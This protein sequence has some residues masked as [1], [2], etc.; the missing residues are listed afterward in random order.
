MPGRAALPSEPTLREARPET[1]AEWVTH[2]PG[3]PVRLATLCSMRLSAILVA[4]CLLP[5]PITSQTRWTP[6]AGAPTDFAPQLAFDPIQG[7]M[8]S[9]G[10]GPGLG[11]FNETWAEIGGAWRRIESA[12]IPSARAH[13]RMVTDWTRSRVVCF[14]GALEFLASPPA[15]DETWEWDGVDWQRRTTPNRPAARPTAWRS[16]AVDRSP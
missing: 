4:V 16:T 1:F 2:A 7:R 15:S 12:H 10:P 13:H 9:F 5:L 6:A 11:T 14:G 3:C 8:M